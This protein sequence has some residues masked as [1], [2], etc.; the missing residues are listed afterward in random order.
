MY[1]YD[2]SKCEWRYWEVS[3][4]NLAKK[5]RQH[6]LLLTPMNGNWTENGTTYRRHQSLKRL[7]RRA[8]IDHAPLRYSCIVYVEPCICRPLR[9][10]STTPRPRNSEVRTGNKGRAAKLCTWRSGRCVNDLIT[11][12]FVRDCRY[13]GTAAEIGILTAAKARS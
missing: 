6:A 9:L 2:E 10:C 3:F 8:A 4:R 11:T 13:I 5:R 7:F 12:L 1:V